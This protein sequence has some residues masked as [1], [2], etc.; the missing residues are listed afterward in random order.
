MAT[1]DAP[2]SLKNVQI[3]ADGDLGCAELLCQVND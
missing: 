3:F 1:L 2:V